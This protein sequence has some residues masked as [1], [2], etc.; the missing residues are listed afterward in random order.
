MKLR[1]E[2]RTWAGSAIDFR[3]AE[4]TVS[5]ETVF[6]AIRDSEDERVTCPEPRPIHGHVGLVVPDI[7]FDRT[8]ALSAAARSRGSHAPVDDE[9]RAVRERLEALSPASINLRSARRRVADASGAESEL[10]ERVA[11]LQGRVRALRDTGGDP[12]TAEAEL[13]T[14]TGELAEAETERIAAEQALAT[15]R[16]QARESRENRRERLR[17]Q[18]RE[19]NL[20]REARAHLAE[21][22]RSEFDAA[23]DRFSDEDSTAQA[24][25]VLHV[26]DV[27]APVVVACETRF[28]SVESAADWLDAP[29]V[30]V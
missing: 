16:E 18:D 11:S 14:A 12:T 20:R 13:A 9:L 26:A 5:P 25:A 22:L 21:Q 17:L 28:E 10:R 15:A 29:V 24:L 2:G 27:R 19:R 23:L 4:T 7:E 3:G 6:E 30:R 8:D 1:F